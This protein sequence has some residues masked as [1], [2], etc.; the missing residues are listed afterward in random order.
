MDKVEIPLRYKRREFNR[1]SDVLVFARHKRNM[2][3]IWRYV[4]LGRGGPT[5]KTTLYSALL[6]EGFDAIEI[7][8][9][10]CDLVDYKDNENHYIVDYLYKR[11]IVVLNKPIAI[12]EKE[13]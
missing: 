10:I 5:G 2:R 7:S 13:N 11:M 8:E 1:P 12:K 6:D 4:I 3:E 9:D